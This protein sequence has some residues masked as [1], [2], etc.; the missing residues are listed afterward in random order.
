MTK[1]D[2]DADRGAVLVRHGKGGKRREVEMDRWVWEQFAPWLTLRA[3]LP[4][5]AL[6]CVL[7]GPTRGRPWTPAGV[8]T[9]LHQAAARAGVRRRLAPH[10]LRHAHALEMSREG[11]PLLVIQRQLGHANL[12]THLRLPTRHRQ[13]RDR[14]HR[15]RTTSTHDP[16]PQRANSALNQGRGR[17]S[18]RLTPL[19]A[20]LV[21][22][23]SK[24]RVEMS[25][26]PE[27]RAPST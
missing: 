23:T 18:S 5:G 25:P 15:P 2:L 17:S 10:H 22:G 12:R 27:R 3:T 4:V 20:E 11:V 6:L 24:T 13:H 19:S 9:Q 16:R 7:R 8:R 1:S 14:P 21:S 26:P